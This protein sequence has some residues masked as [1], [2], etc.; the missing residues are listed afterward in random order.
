MINV[1]VDRGISKDVEGGI[2]LAEALA[3]ELGGVVGSSRA[4]VDS[5]WISPDHQVGQTGKTVHPKLY[6]ALGISGAI[7]HLA[8][9]QESECIVAV[10]KN[11]AAPIFE[12]ADYG[13]CGDLFKVAPLL[14]D[15]IKA[16]KADK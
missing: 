10:N 15:A 12:I 6:I 5:G 1:S 4:V 2:K 9:M 7:Q 16:A 13:I 3:E 8:G 11:D 14:L